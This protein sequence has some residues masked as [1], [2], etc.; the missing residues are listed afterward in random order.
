MSFDK[1][2]IRAMPRRPK[3]TMRQLS[4]SVYAVVGIAVIVVGWRVWK[5]LP[6][7][8]GAPLEDET[9]SAFVGGLAPDFSLTVFDTGETITL[10]A[11]IWTTA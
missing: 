8:S 6:F 1:S 3:P 10:S 4:T 9:T 5:S 7:N 2:R 11:A